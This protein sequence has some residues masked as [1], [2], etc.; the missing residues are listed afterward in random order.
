M[1]VSLMDSMSV[2]LMTCAL[3]ECVSSA[4]R[5]DASTPSAAASVAGHQ[6]SQ[7]APSTEKMTNATGRTLTITPQMTCLRE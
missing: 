4:M 5:N 2:F 3:I 7:I 6:P 1:L